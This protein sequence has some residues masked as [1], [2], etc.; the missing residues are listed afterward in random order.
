MAAGDRTVVDTIAVSAGLPCWVNGLTRPGETAVSGHASECQPSERTE[1]QLF[2]SSAFLF[3][4]L[5]V[6]GL[7][8]WLLIIAANTVECA[9]TCSRYRVSVRCLL[10]LCGR[11]VWNYELRPAGRVQF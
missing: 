10:R 6:F 4:W 11:G 8:V 7:I 5:L 1:G 3:V 2:V 9:I